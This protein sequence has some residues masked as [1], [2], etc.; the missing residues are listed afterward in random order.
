MSNDIRHSVD[1]EASK[2]KLCN[3][4]ILAFSCIY[5]WRFLWFFVAF[6]LRKA[7]QT[8]PQC[9]NCPTV[10]QQ[11][12]ASFFYKHLNILTK[13]L[14]IATAVP[15]GT[16]RHHRGIGI[17]GYTFVSSIQARSIPPP[18]SGCA[19]TGTTGSLYSL[20]WTCPPSILHKGAYAHNLWLYSE[21]CV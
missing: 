5:I 3:C 7:N 12:V 9:Q 10:S 16:Q 20:K 15:T 13:P 17:P 21:I 1:Q 19:H 14:L 11:C 4:N 6:S 2:L 18:S 8:M